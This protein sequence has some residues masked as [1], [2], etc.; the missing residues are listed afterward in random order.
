MFSD[1]AITAR[2]A[3]GITDA[4]LSWTRDWTNQMM[5]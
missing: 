5:A 4:D 3:I 2:S 1:A